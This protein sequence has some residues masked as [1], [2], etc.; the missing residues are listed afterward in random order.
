MTIY[1]ISSGPSGP[2]VE[3]I[4]LVSPLLLAASWSPW[5]AAPDRDARFLV[6]VGDFLPSVLASYYLL[7][8]LAEEERSWIAI[9]A[10]ILYYVAFEENPKGSVCSRNSQNLFQ[11]TGADWC[12]FQVFLGSDITPLRWQHSLHFPTDSWQPQAPDDRGPWRMK[13]VGVL[14]KKRKVVEIPT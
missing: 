13:W 6:G 11:H 9:S 12:P 8:Q 5:N 14:Y 3:W 4:F 10:T 1:V 2:L 7:W